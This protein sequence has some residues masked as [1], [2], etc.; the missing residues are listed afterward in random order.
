MAA[1]LPVPLPLIQAPMAGVSTP[2]LAAAVSNAGALGSIAIG[3]TT[4]DNARDMIERTRS[5]TDRPFNVNVFCHRTP[6]IDVE[7][8]TN[9]LTG[10][11]PLFTR[12]GAEPPERLDTIYTSFNDDPAMQALLCEQQPAVVSFH[13]GLPPQSVID[14]LKARSITLLATA[15]TLAEGRAIEAAGIDVIVAQ[16]S[17]AGGHRGVFAPERGDAMLGVLPLVRML[18]QDTSIP[19]IAAGG[20]MDGAGIDAVLAAGACGAQLGTAFIA[21][22]ESAAS[23]THRAWLAGAHSGE[24]VVTSAISGR[25][26]RA[27]V[28]GHT[29][30]IAPIDIPDYPRAYLAGKALSAAASNAGGEMFRVCWA[31]QGAALSRALPAGELITRLCNESKSIMYLLKYS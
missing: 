2:A 28:N 11:A 15:T 9:W 22:P 4:V 14:A 6:V 31:G 24:T 10:L 13:F 21:C 27:L 25:P 17:E 26:A 12:F 3:A 16:G 23:D 30:E 1:V 19:V 7:R 5:L 8:E 20:I 29:R 18:V